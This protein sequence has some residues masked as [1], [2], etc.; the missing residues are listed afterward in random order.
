MASIHKDPR[1]KSPYYYAAFYGMDGRRKFKSTKTAERKKA[2]RLAV[3]WGAA[4]EKA[5]A[6]KLYAAQARRVLAEILTEATGDALTEFSVAEWFKQF[7]AEKKGS[8]T[9]ATMA[10]Y[11]QVLDDFEKA[12]GAKSKGPLAAVTVGDLVAYRDKLR[13]EG[14]SAST[15]NQTVRKILAVP[16]S[17][18][19]RLGYITVNPCAGVAPIKDREETRGRGREAFTGKE[20]VALLKAAEGT[21][22]EGMTLLAATTGLRLGDAAQITWGNLD[23]TA[24]LLTVETRKTATVVRIPLHADF[25]Q[26]LKKRTRGIGK[27]PIFPDLH[28]LKISGRNGLSAGFKAVMDKAKIR[29]KAFALSG[30]GRTFYSKGFHSL[31]HTFVSDLAN[32]GV[33]MELRQKLAGHA[34][35]KV[36][37]CYTHHQIE[38]LRAAVEKLPRRTA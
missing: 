20:V 23:L 12:I 18:A 19:L 30:A 27:A 36:H 8:A 29:S 37:A 4:A 2:M 13:E 16:F 28:K 10:R 22:W 35:E 14:R 17:A 11:K 25:R 31:R 24:G 38:T 3:E 34:D 32:A 9:T 33:A 7:L 1:G 21:D 5:R 6:G 15:V 26:W